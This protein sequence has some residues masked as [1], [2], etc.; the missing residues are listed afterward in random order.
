M[1][2]AALPG[3]VIALYRKRT[4]AFGIW[5]IILGILSLPVG[6]YVAPFRPDHAAIVLFLPTALLV[7]EL[8]VSIIDWSPFKN[9]PP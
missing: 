8:L 7:A 4:R 1:L 9:Y 6:F 5:T 3:L 2:F